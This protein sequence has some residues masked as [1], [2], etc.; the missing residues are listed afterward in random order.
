MNFIR[1]RLLQ[2]SFRNLLMLECL[3]IVGAVRSA[4]L[5]EMAFKSIAAYLEVGQIEGR[6]SDGV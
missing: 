3:K 1:A 2:L 5:F 4:S 6:I